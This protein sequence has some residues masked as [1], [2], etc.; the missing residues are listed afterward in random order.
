MDDAKISPSPLLMAMTGIVAGF[1]QGSMAIGGGIIMTTLMSLTTDMPQHSIIASTLGASALI[2]TSATLMHYKMGNVHVKGALMIS[3]TAAAA[4]FAASQLALK[5]DE[6][7]L[8]SCLGG[9]LVVSS[10]SMLK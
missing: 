5:L 4:A 7:V 6:G 10:I 9:A 3:A 8:R 2:N 1:S